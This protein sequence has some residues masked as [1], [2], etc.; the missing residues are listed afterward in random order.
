MLRLRHKLLLNSFLLLDVVVLIGTLS[1]LASFKPQQR[2]VRDLLE[3]P[4]I[5][6]ISSR[7][8]ESVVLFLSWAMILKSVVGYDSSRFAP[9]SRS[10]RDVLKATFLCALLVF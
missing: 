6:T 5:A 7:A 1:L 9:L 10:L 4:F 8:L 3:S 2:S